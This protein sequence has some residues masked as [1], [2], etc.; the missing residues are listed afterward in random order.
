MGLA[1][2][3]C[4][5]RKRNSECQSRMCLS[6][7]VESD[8]KCTQR[9]HLA[10]KASKDTILF[11]ERK[12][13]AG[14]KPKTQPRPKAMIHTPPAHPTITS[15]LQQQGTTTATTTTTSNSAGAAAIKDYT[16]ETTS[17]T[18]PPLSSYPPS[19]PPPFAMQNQQPSHIPR[20][21]STPTIPFHPDQ[22]WIRDHDGNGNAQ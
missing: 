2:V 5:W 11:L 3:R 18:P 7:C 9:S 12:I 21:D 10:A 22:Q 1:C 6:Y 17:H 20:V 16:T 19:P 8:C 4:C 15:F 14:K 13:K